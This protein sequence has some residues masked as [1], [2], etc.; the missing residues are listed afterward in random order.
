MVRCDHSLS[1]ILMPRLL[2]VPAVVPRCLCITNAA[3]SSD[4]VLQILSYVIYADRMVIGEVLLALILCLVPQ[5]S[6][7]THTLKWQLQ[8]Q[9]QMAAPDSG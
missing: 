6:P 4:C 3:D 7:R 2:A 9:A 1:H 8:T 5:C